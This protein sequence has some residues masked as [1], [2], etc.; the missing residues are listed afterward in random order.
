MLLSV[1]AATVLSSSPPS[2]LFARYH[3]TPK[4]CYDG[5]TCTMDLHLGLGVTLTS[6]SIRLCDI[7]TPE[8][9]GPEKERA[10]AARKRVIELTMVADRVEVWVPQKMRCGPSKCD[11]SDKYGR[12]LGWIIAD[13]IE[14]NRLLVKEGLAEPYMEQCAKQ[15]PR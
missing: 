10:Q 6:A 9:R 15:S 13:G 2:L 1:L 7:D 8:L 5:D 12:I 3:A 14:V 11:K 4:S